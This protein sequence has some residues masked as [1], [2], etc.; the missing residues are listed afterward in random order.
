[1]VG[2]RFTQKSE[3]TSEIDAGTVELF[4]R[5]DGI[6]WVSVIAFSIFHIG[7]IAALFFFTWPAFLTAVAL[8]WV[9]LSFGIG[10]GY[11]RLLTHRSYKAPKWFEYFLA[12]CGTL[13]LEGGPII[14][15]ATHRAH[16]RFA[17][18]Y[19]DPHTPR[20]GKWWAHVVWMLVGKACRC[21]LD[22]CSRFAPDMVK[23]RFHV[24]LSSTTACL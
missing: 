7:A 14:W 24:W 16:H 17:D 23:D 8:Y 4:V 21:D 20:E 6:N 1:V 11:H 3:L 5:R 2:N 13:A 15:V 12:V 18:Q 9:S 10:M 19:G 22:V